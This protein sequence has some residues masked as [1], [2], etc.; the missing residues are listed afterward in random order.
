MN[1][2]KYPNSN[3]NKNNINKNK[4]NILLK[5]VLITMINIRNQTNNN[6]FLKIIRSHIR[7]LIKI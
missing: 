5:K 3:H 7:D 4:V 2:N 1:P 6:N